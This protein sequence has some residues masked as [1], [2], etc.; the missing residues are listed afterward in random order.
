[1]AKA[2][3][4]QLEKENKRGLRRKQAKGRSR[5]KAQKHKI[6]PRIQLFEWLLGE[7]EDQ[8]PES[9][10]SIERWRLLNPNVI[11]GIAVLKKGDDKIFEERMRI[12]Y[13]EGLRQVFL[14]LP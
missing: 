1:M 14:D 10:T 4:K 5:K 9:G 13:D 11:E 2:E 3:P 12:F 6:H 7:Y 8:T